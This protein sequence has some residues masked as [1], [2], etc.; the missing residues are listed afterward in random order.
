MDV[1]RRPNRS[2]ISLAL[3]SIV[4]AVIGALPSPGPSAA[5][6]EAACGK[7]AS[8]QNDVET[9][10]AA[11]GA[12]GASRLDQPLFASDR[13]RTGASSRA[14]I[15]YSDQ[16]LHRINEKSEVEIQAPEAGNPGVLKVLSGQHYFSTR[17]PKDYGRVETPTVTAA[18]RGTEFVVEVADG[19]T[20]T[21]TMIEGAIDASNQ[22]G[23]L[24]VTAGEAAYV[25][26]G[27]APVKRIVVRPLD[28]VSWSLY[29]PKLLGG[30]DAESVRSM[31]AE[32][33]ELA[34]A[35]ELLAVGQVSQAGERIAGVRGQRPNDPL[36]LALASVIELVA[37]RK[38]EALQ[39]AQ[40]AH[41]S[42]PDSAAAAM[43]LS[44][45]RQAQFEI[46]E[47]RRMAEV[48]VGLDPESAE[49]LA[50][51]AELRMAEGDTRGARDAAERA[52][53]R[54]PESARALA[55]LGFVQL[56]ELRTDDAIET[57]RQA[58]AI[59][60]NFPLARLGHGIALMRRNLAAGRE[61]LQTAVIL[62]PES[63]LYRSYLAKAYF[64]EKRAGAATK[65]LE[66]AK[67]LD[68]SDPTPWLYD[69]L[70]KQTTN[71]PVEALHDLQKSIELNDQRAVY[72]SRLLLD[73]DLAVRSA[74]LANIYN[75]LGFDRLGMVTARRSADI[76]Q[77]NFSSHL[78]LA[79]TY[80]NLPGF[81]PAFLSETLQARIYQP[82]NVNAVRP[83][84]V[85]ESVSFNEYTS[86]LDRPRMR[87]FAGVSYGSTNTNLDEYF[88]PGALCFD[89]SGNIGPC[90]DVLAV[91]S[92]NDSGGDVT[93]TLNRDRFAGAVSYETFQSDGFRVN[94]DT[95]E[96]AIR[97]FFMVAPTHR[98]QIQV[99]IIDGQ[100]QSGDL[101]LRG[102]PALIG[103]E[104][105]DTELTNVGLGYR[106]I[107]SPAAD[108]AVS[109][110]Y[111]KT[112]Q[113]AVIQNPFLPTPATSDGELEGSQIEAQY[114]LR[115]ERI[116]WTAGLGAFRGDQTIDSADSFGNTASAKGDDEFSN[117]YLYAR[118]RGL[119][120]LEI[121]AGLSYEDVLAPVGLL[122]P[123]DSNILIA[124]LP[125]EDSQ[126]SGK[127]G[128][129]LQAGART[130]I[131]A[132]V[133]SRL[134]P[135]IGRLQTLEPTQVAGF[136]QFY[137]DP[138]GTSSFNYGIGLDQ[139]FPHGLFAGFS[140]LRRDLD[141][142]EP[143]CAAPD[144][145]LGCGFQVAS[146]VVERTSDDWLGNVY[147]NATVGKRV[148][149]GVE[150]AY[151]ERDFD[152]TQVSNNSLF[153][154]YVE[155]R[156]L[157]PQVRFYLPMG[158]YAVLAA[159]H[160][161]QQVDQFDDLSSP[162]RLP[163]EADF[164]IGDLDIGCR[165]PKRWGSVRL[166]VRNVTDKEFDYYRSSLEES[167]VPARTVL[168]TLNLTTP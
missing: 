6:G 81:A 45:A 41:E 115:R 52:V 130:A 69:A 42:D 21:I 159:S 156:R 91:D 56:A 111:S 61:E 162:T 83:D 63:S 30:A 143:G 128:L 1:E 70:L 13:I 97:A 151:E 58:V 166:A 137:D 54:D 122:P 126:V 82:V 98:D 123:R 28:A 158:L 20:T 133:H 80:R 66:S 67:A 2:S 101:P 19:G 84:V 47:A 86:L 106:R 18:I 17:R 90:R 64:E 79:G 62:D 26:P 95:D 119:G 71:R 43:A 12:W 14:A 125:Y 164:W 7:L 50:R 34:E 88:D 68:P 9:R 94:N 150:Y 127:L 40:R 114:V 72:R 161:D 15:L 38:D 135:A 157:R 148:A 49:A 59:D 89:P 92:S 167:V 22:F 124:D 76:D 78:F 163:I 105:I 85:N 93:F 39:L 117:A 118:F 108:L 4:L 141:I 32:G 31:G 51:V 107:L 121:S 120:P 136:N 29:Y 139:S 113:T 24:R 11:T 160:Y 46:G 36:A 112:N 44:F 131:R 146:Q 145:L 55:V 154:D 60:P 5:A 27:K 103:L 155:T 25:E 87:G 53:R 8:V 33:R 96:D 153:E 116:T 147:F 134:T 3:V 109:A 65:E 57:F 48:A 35:A 100:R 99:N 142:P 144:P 149:L 75:D 16:T 138:A 102:F 110:I 165:M 104:R 74:D 152:Y 132:T 23:E 168:L 37:D 140:V 129:S 10:P 73:E 77:S